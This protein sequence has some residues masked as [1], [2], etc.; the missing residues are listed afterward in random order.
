[1]RA[2]FLLLFLL[3]CSSIK[4]TPQDNVTN[5]AIPEVDEVVVNV[6]A[7][8]IVTRSPLLPLILYVSILSAG[9]FIGWRKKWL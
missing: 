6:S 8:P 4:D 3:S 5:V 2:T 7:N 9:L 1:M